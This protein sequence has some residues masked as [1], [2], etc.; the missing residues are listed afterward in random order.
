MGPLQVAPQDVSGAGEAIATKKALG[1]SD[2]KGFEWR[3]LQNA[4][5][6]AP[7]G[8]HFQNC[9]SREIL[10]RSLTKPTDTQAPYD[11]DVPTFITTDR[12]PH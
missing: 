7:S 10:G 3:K 11:C 4:G 9:F 8:S 2:K 1:R 6:Q 12:L 5:P